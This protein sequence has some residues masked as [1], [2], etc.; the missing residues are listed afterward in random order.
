MNKNKAKTVEEY[1][2]GFPKP[3]QLK[4]KKIRKIVKKNAPEAF[5]KIGYG[6]P[7]YS[8]LG[9]LLYFAAYEKHIGFYAMP[10]T[11]LHFEKQ[12]KKYSTSKGTVRFEIDQD[13]P[14][15]L[16]TKIVK[17]RVKENYDKKKIKKNKP[18]LFR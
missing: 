4:L 3:V 2:A 11:I 15:S 6:M 7:A 16:L 8:Y 18:N 10:S 9:V 5:E 1:I 17:Y 14:E 13:I 12:L